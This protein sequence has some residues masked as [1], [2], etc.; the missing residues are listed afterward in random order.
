MKRKQ[1]V[2]ISI[3]ISLLCYSNL[4]A[5]KYSSNFGFS[6]I[7]PNNWYLYSHLDDYKTLKEAQEAGG[8]YFHITNYNPDTAPGTSEFRENDIKIAIY[9][10]KLNNKSID[11]WIK[12]QCKNNE[13][14]ILSK[15]KVLLGNKSFF[16]ILTVSGDAEYTIF[17]YSNG[18]HIAEFVFYPPYTKQLNKIIDIIKTFEFK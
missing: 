16:K 9:F 8:N 4:N 3:I 17:Y 18:K 14:K 7:Y 11:N 10:Y 13:S 15:T 5:N 1:L 2:F 12:V 6:I